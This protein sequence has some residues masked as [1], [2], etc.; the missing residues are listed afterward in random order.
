[1]C[2]EKPNADFH[3]TTEE[4]IKKQKL[5][6]EEIGRFFDK[7]GYQP[8]AGRIL[9]LLMTMDKERFTFEEITEELNI[10]KSS[11][12]NVL[13]NLELRKSIEYIT[14]PGDRKRYYCIKKQNSFEL[15]DE[16]EQNMRLIKTMFQNIIELKADPDSENSRFFKEVIKMID[17]YLDTMTVVREK[18]HKT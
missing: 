10:S 12:S 11:A 14:V 17:L 13:R 16:F 4:R 7:Q 3:M 9:G 5:M 1:M 2:I 15:I 6:I 18:F 8:I